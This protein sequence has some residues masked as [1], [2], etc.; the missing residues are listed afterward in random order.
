MAQ[1]EPTQRPSCGGWHA[2]AITILV[3]AVTV[4]LAT[5]AVAAIGAIPSDGRFSACYQSSDNVLNRI[6]VLAEPGEQCPATYTRVTWPAQASGGATGP[7]GPAGP[8]GPAG[9]AG[10]S[11]ISVSVATRDVVLRT[12]DWTKRGATAVV[13]CPGGRSAV[14]GGAVI[15]EVP[16]NA[17]RPAPLNSYPHVVKGRP[18]GWAFRPVAMP[19]LGVHDTFVDTRDSRGHSHNVKLPDYAQIS[20]PRPFSEVPARV[21]VYALCVPRTIGAPYTP[22]GGTRKG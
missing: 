9:Q 6:L 4:V 3:T 20:Q 18:V 8:P 19:A 10:G 5:H 2:Q 16:G 14:G 13:T 11:G 22:G 15:S 12:S 1:E 7:A 17:I 21:T